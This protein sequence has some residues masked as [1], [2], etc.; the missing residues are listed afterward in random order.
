M[1]DEEIQEQFGFG[2]TEETKEDASEVS[3]GQLDLLDGVQETLF[4]VPASW[5]EH[6]QGMPSY[7][8]QDLQPWASVTVHFKD[9]ADRTAFAKLVEQTIT[10]RTKSLWYPEAKIAHMVGKEYRAAEEVNPIYPVYII[11]KGRADTRLTSKALETLHVPYHIVVEPQ[12]YDAY[13]AVIDPAK[14]LQ[15]PFSNLGQG[16]IPARNWVWEHAIGTGAK[17]HWIL[18]DNIGSFHRFQDNLKCFVG[19]GAIFRAAEEFVDRYENVAISGFNYFMFVTRKAKDIPPFYLNTRIYSCILIQNDIPYRWR[20]RYNEDTD[21]CIRALKDGWCTVLF[22]AFLALKSTTMT[23]KGGNTDELYVDDGRLKMAESLRDQHPDIVTITEKWGRPQ[24]QVDY[25][26]FKRNKLKLRED[27]VI[28]EGSDDF[29][30]RLQTLKEEDYDAPEQ[31][32]PRDDAAG[33]R[34]EAE[35]DG[36]EQSADCAPTG[37]IREGGRVG[38]NAAPIAAEMAAPSLFETHIERGCPGCPN[39]VLLGGACGYWERTGKAS[40][41][42]CEL[43]KEVVS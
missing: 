10:D 39:Y 18:D 38:W 20:G 1:S 40:P 6:W 16:S 24:H 7:Q 31:D 21:L 8:H 34:G 22:N 19:D 12:E 17:R 11:S 9:R 27:I 14:I 29:G 3:D 28:P 36:D 4:D 37:D 41:A 26:G 32:E 43:A 30:M 15:L 2:Q 13:A 25:R 23:M 33:L 42:E 35:G 5:E